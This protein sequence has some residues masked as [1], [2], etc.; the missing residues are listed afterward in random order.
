MAASRRD[1]RAGGLEH[2]RA[3]RDFT[4]T[5]EP[6]SGTGGKR[7]PRRGK[8]LSFVVQKHAARRLHYDLLLELDDVLKSWAVPQ[9]PSLD[10]GERRLAVHVEDHPYA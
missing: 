1:G 3:K 7:K 5:P 4:R 9:G 10:P 2:Y 8:G 6:R